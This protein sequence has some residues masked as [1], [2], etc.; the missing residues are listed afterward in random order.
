MLRGLAE[1]HGDVGSAESETRCLSRRV[2]PLSQQTTL[3]M[4]LGDYESLGKR[5]RERPDEGDRSPRQS[6]GDRQVDYPPPWFCESS[7]DHD[8]RD[9][10]KNP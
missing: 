6:A 5:V 8:G 7:H 4:Y 9:Y 3:S 10:G 1:D 2:D